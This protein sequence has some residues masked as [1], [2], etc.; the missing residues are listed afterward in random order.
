MG[1][2]NDGLDRR[3]PARTRVYEWVRHGI[4]RGELPAGSFLEEET[5]CAAVGVSRT[6]VREAFHQLAAEKFISLSPRRGAQV[7]SVTA[8]DLTEMY[9]MRRV[10]E[11]YACE[12]LIERGIRPQREIY[13][14]LATMSEP[15][16]VARCVDGDE[17]E[18]FESIDLDRRF[19]RTIVAA[20]GNTVL[21]E[22]YDHLRSRQQR[23]AL[24]AVQAQPERLSII[25]EQHAA[26]TRAI[27]EGDAEAAVAVLA[28]HLRPIATITAKLPP[29]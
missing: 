12:N 7:T 19:H 9:E 22:M 3:L 5:I 28:E 16:R 21:T 25:N 14:L 29:Q 26:L 1:E 8:R 13:D 27:A 20:T 17:D 24:S 11:G 2:V 4:L 6:P 23:V 18:W 15:D 10:L